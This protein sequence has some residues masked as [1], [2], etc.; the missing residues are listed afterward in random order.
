[1]QIAQ[2]L[3]NSWRNKYI[4]KGSIDRIEPGVYY[5]PA[6]RPE[7]IQ[8]VSIQRTRPVNNEIHYISE[9]ISSGE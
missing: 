1:M 6:W 8:I 5:Q 4:S 2:W 9:V 3:L 7:I